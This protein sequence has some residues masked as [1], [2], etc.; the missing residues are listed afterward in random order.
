MRYNL[1]THTFRCHHASGDDRAY[2]EA[3]IQAGMHTLGFADHSPQFFPTNHYSHFRMRP[4]AAAK[5]VASLRALKEEYKKDIRILI[6]FET[7][8]YPAIFDDLTAFIAPL[9][10]DYLIMGQHFLRNEYEALHCRAD[11]PSREEAELYVQQTLEGLQ[12]GAFTYIA[13]PDI[14]RHTDPVF[15]R[16][17]MT[18]FCRRLKSMRIPVEYNILGYRKQT[19][20]PHPAFWQIVAETGNH[21]VLGYD[22]H[23]PEALLDRK[24]YDTCLGC[25]NALGITPIRFGDIVIRKPTENTK[26]SV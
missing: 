7:E 9:E 25:L 3:A 13:H 20:Y 11:N 2:I 24:T 12:T 23:N 26:R 18:D 15:Y 17:L 6:G 1:H 19:W 4:E 5:Y 21:V 14:F 8:Y 10:L 22:A 16:E